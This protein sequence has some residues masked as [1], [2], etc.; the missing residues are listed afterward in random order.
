MAQGP[1]LYLFHDRQCPLC[2]RF[3]A[4]LGK[5]NRE[6]AIEVVDVDG[7][8]TAARFPDMDLKAARAELTVRDR[9]G[10]TARGVEALRRLSRLLPGLRRLAWIYRLPGVTPAVGAAY[11]TVHRHRRRLCLNC[12][13]KWMP[14]LKF[15]RR[16]KGR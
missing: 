8:D 12:G 7:Q 5:W 2:R 15:S 14:S 9:L 6:G 16:R 3:A 4:A 1:R 13:E 10:N 11:R